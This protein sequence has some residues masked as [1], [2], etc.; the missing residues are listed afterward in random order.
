MAVSDG[1]IYEFADFRLIPKDNLLLRDGEP[2]SLPPKAFSTLVLLV[3]NQGHLVRKEELIEKLW[4]DAFVDEA[5]VSRC[6]WTIR[7]ALGEDSKSQRFIQTVPKRGYKFVAEV[8]EIG[9]PAGLVAEINGS[10]LPSTVSNSVGE[11]FV[12]SSILGIAPIGKL[13]D[14]FRDRWKVYAVV[15]VVLLAVSVVIA[16]LTT[17]RTPSIDKRT[18][19]IAVLPFK[20]VSTVNGDALFEFGIAESLINKLSVVENFHVRS[21]SSVR[22]YSEMNADPTAAGTEQKVEYVLTSNY[23]IVDGKIRITAQLIDVAAGKTVDAYDFQKDMPDTFTAQDAVAFE[24][25][26]RLKAKFGNTEVGSSTARGTNNE[27]AYRLYLLAQNFNELRGLENGR[28]AL[29]Q[30][31]RAVAL[32]PNFAR[33]WATKAYIHRYLGYGALATEHSLKSIDAVQ[34]AIALDPNLSEAH[35][36]LCFNQFRFEYDFDAAERSCK[37][38]IELDPN[39]PLAHKL[40]SNFL[41]TRG[42]FEESLAEIVKAIDLQPVSYDNQQTYALALYFARRYAESETQLK[43]LTVLNPNHNLI[44]GQLV[45]SLVQQGKE[46]EALEHLI[47]LLTLEKENEE[48]VR[49]FRNIYSRSGWRGVT[50]ERI[51]IAELKGNARSYELARLYAAVGDKSS[52]FR[53]LERA[54]EERSNMIAVI[55]VDPEL[56]P[57]RE[58]PRYIELVDLI[59]QERRS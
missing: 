41:Y 4:A 21:L 26:D 9:D 3:E 43:Q 28:I 14:N 8:S 44:Y 10:G 29:E 32:D 2:V 45:R 48:T 33:A 58:D 13:K 52:A 22:R 54:Y 39:S 12:D 57:L 18:V 6:I 23:Q 53:N 36:T 27:E 59:G 37:R 24:L 55:E 20:S 30:I 47:K 11:D 46:S 49:R 16:Y 35:S 42:R 51:R 34:K 15:P 25:K 17:D 1:T 5:A 19:T 38:A 56:D 40:Y 7:N 31:D 50:L